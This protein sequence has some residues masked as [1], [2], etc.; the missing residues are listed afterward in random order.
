MIVSRNV[1]YATH[2]TVKPGFG[3]SCFGSQIHG[4]DPLLP[5]PEGGGA[6]SGAVGVEDM[7]RPHLIFSVPIQKLNEHFHQL[8]GCQ[9]ARTVL[10]CI[11]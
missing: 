9:G 6:P 8:G 2:M 5:P 11:A 7:A 3:Y 10:Q 4:G 1:V